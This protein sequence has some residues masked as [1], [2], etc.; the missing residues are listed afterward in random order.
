MTTLAYHLLVRHDV[1]RMA[2]LPIALAIIAVPPAIFW[3]R[4]RRFEFRLETFNLFNWVNFD[5]PAMNVGNQN[6]FGR[7]TNSLRNPREMQMA[8]KFYF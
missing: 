3:Y 5:F 4:E 1:P 7:I 2:Y 6:T 8:V